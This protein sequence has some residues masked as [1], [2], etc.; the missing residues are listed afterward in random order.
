MDPQMIRVLLCLA[1]TT[2]D[3]YTGYD[4]AIW[5]EIRLNRAGNLRMLHRLHHP[6]QHRHRQ[7]RLQLQPQP[8]KRFL[9]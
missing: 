1:G 4:P 9:I 7:Q 3:K 6:H 2:E 8:H 5:F